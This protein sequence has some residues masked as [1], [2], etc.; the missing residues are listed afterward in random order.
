[1]EFNNSRAYSPVFE[2]RLVLPDWT[3][4]RPQSKSKKYAE[5]SDGLKTK[6]LG[7]LI[8]GFQQPLRDVQYNPSTPKQ[9][10]E[11]REN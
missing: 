7:V 8:V 5:K 10:L 1:M 9:K 11:S 4:T 6:A 3:R 2:M